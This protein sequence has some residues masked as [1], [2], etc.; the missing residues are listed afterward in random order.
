MEV[1]GMATRILLI[2]YD[3]GSHLPFFPQ[4]IAYL[5]SS[6]RKEGHY[7]EIYSQDIT[8]HSEDHLTDFLTNRHFD[9]VGFGFIAGYFQYAKALAISSAIK[10]S[11][12]SGLYILGGHGPAAAPEYF[13]HKCSANVVVVGDGED[14][15]CGYADGS[16][17]NR[18]LWANSERDPDDIPW[19]DYELFP[20]E[21]YRLHRFP[22][23]RNTDFT[24]P[25]LSGRGC[26]WACTFC[27]R[28]D[29]SFRPRTAKA[30]I[31]EMDYL[32]TRW[33]INHFQF[34]DELFMSSKERIVTF[35]DEMLRHET[36]KWAKW[37]CNGRLNYA[38]PEVLKIMKRAGCNY[39]NYGC[40]SLSQEAL[41]RMKK[42]L[43]VGQIYRGVEATKELGIHM[44][45][46]FMWGN[47]GDTYES[48]EAAVAF[49][50]KY[51]GVAELRTIRPVSPYPG[52]DLFRDATK[53]NLLSGVAEFYQFRHRNSD[54][55][56]VSFMDGIS[57]WEGD[58]ALARAN[59]ELVSAY[60]QRCTIATN[61][62][63]L[64]FYAGVTP[65]GEFRGF[66]SV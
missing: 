14:A 64:R 60:H 55:F 52:S 11:G 61:K 9:I 25:I 34:S 58:D 31:E 15:I 7:V 62:Q 30:V 4:G 20:I 24:M 40:E 17:K 43:T 50:K 49:L 1:G 6:L 51:D 33:N 23:S 63:A 32:H 45:L 2:V 41:N 8:H 44:G 65:A 59:T 35:C 37:D 47:Y 29:K 39:I 19:P 38:T 46:N 26:K 57:E 16:F 13:L 36:Q 3:N 54:L 12:F 22:G 21:I 28:M 10:D 27:Y 42:G 5:A 56:T 66:R 18:V 48:L 53:R